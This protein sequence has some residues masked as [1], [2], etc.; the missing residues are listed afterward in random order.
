MEVFSDWLKYSENEAEFFAGSGMQAVH[1]V[2]D[3]HDYFEENYGNLPE[4]KSR[5]ARAMQSKRYEILSGC[6]ILANTMYLLYDADVTIEEA[7]QGKAYAQ[8]HPGEAVFLAWFT[9]ELILKLVA[10]GKYYFTAKPDVLWNYFD[11]LLWLLT[12]LLM[13]FSATGVNVSF[14][15]VLRCLKLVRIIHMLHFLEFTR[16][17]RTMME[18][19]IQS[20]LTLIWCMLMIIFFVLLFALFFVQSCSVAL[21]NSDADSALTDTQRRDVIAYF[22]S[23]ELSV[24]SL[25]MVTTGGFDW[26]IVYF[27]LVPVGNHAVAGIVFFV[28]FFQIAVWNVVT[29]IFVDKALQLAK[30]DAEKALLQKRKTEFMDR[31]IL[32]KMMEKYNVGGSG[33]MSQDEFTRLM[34]QS[35]F[36]S[37]LQDR[38]IEI[39]EAVTFFSMVAAA[40]GTEEVDLDALALSCLRIRGFATGIDLNVLRYETRIHLNGIS[41][42]VKELR[43]TVHDLTKTMNNADSRGMNKSGTDNADFADT[44]KDTMMPL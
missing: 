1:K 39:K 26:E 5:F 42:S 4:P 30:P 20:A 24:R 6:V 8:I 3:V 17:L 41:S 14:L 36:Q 18:S 31:R 21:L 37:F 35:D 44:T 19:T 7:M 43:D 23:V 10:Q 22:G 33:T 38:G 34:S 27:T 13:A 32:R 15:R 11:A 28:F 16:E 29:S 25:M 2:Q 40:I 12:C 9:I